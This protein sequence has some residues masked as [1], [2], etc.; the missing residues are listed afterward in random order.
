M[1]G[2]NPNTDTM[3]WIFLLLPWIELWTL[4]EL[5]SETGPLVALLYVFA[6]LMLGLSMLRR[7]G[8]AIVRKMQ[9]EQ[10]AGFIAIGRY[11]NC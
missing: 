5:G 6:T 9:R 4:I 3:P 10:G 2:L 8:L 11:G 7:Q 1:A